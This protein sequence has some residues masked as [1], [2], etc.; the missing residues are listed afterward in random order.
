[1]KN[2]IKLLS[3]AT[4]T[5]KQI[6]LTAAA[7]YGNDRMVGYLLESQ[8]DPNIYPDDT[9]GFHT[10]ATPLHHAVSSCSLAS[11]KALI[12]AG[13]D[14]SLKDKVYDGIPLDWAHFLS[15]EETDLVKRE[16]FNNIAHY[17]RGFK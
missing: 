10:H 4:M 9:T 3:T 14:V 17:L 16:Q 6:A 12:G 13:A 15:N 8:I 5:D 1:M 2:V 7:F 11:V